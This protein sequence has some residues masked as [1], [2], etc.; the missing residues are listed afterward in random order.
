MNIHPKHNVYNHGIIQDLEFAIRAINDST[1]E[2]NIAETVKAIAETVP[3][4]SIADV[5]RYYGLGSERQGL[6]KLKRARI[7]IETALKN[8]NR[9]I[10]CVENSQQI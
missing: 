9:A 10:E 4:G 6:L 2:F 3:A 5:E 1:N 7:D 8:I